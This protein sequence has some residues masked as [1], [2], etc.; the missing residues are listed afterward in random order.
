MSIVIAGK[1]VRESEA[2]MPAERLVR[3]LLL[4]GGY[5]SAIALFLSALSEYGLGTNFVFAQCIGYSIYAGV[6]GCSAA[7]GR[8]KPGWLDAV[9]GIPIGFG[10]GFAAAVALNGI[11][12]DEIARNH[13]R[14]VLISA[15]AAVMF[16]ALGTWH[17]RGAASL[18]EARAEARAEGLRRAEQE[19]AAARAELARLQA[20]IEPH[21]LFNTLSN[22]VGLIDAE[23]A[24][25]RRMLIDL[26]ALL[27]TALARTRQPEVSLGEELELLRAYLGI[28]EVRMGSRLQWS[29]DADEKL[30]AARLPP[31]LVQPLVENA[32]RH[33]LEPKAAGGRVA[34]RC[35]E[36]DRAMSIEIE[37]D[38]L[39][40]APGQAAGVGLANVRKRLRACYGD[41]ASLALEEGQGGGVCARIRIPLEF[42]CAS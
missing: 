42:P 18:A 21:F 32:V 10:V 11:P 9:V 14:A 3:D 20:Q 1:Q 26:T 19:A 13:P 29:L 28:M 36:D 33:G 4:V 7:A 41:A 8:R 37:D 22:V 6:M 40:F 24:R 30:L 25:A 15:V 39:G 17:F 2:A 31:L 16:G 23:P 27:R 38:G 35:R 34:V 12:L 5:N